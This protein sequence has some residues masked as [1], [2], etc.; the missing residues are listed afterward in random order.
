MPTAHRCWSRQAEADRSMVSST[1]EHCNS[2]I[3]LQHPAQLA[4]MLAPSK[5]LHMLQVIVSSRC[6][7]VGNWPG[8]GH[9]AAEPRQCCCG[10]GSRLPGRHNPGDT[11]TA[12]SISLAPLTWG[13]M[14]YTYHLRTSVVLS[15]CLQC[16]TCQQSKSPGLR[17]HATGY[18]H[19]QQQQESVV[20]QQRGCIALYNLWK[21]I[22]FSDCLCLVRS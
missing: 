22:D 19:A 2:G 11:P 3:S 15:I 6:G 18:E 21:Q 14:F 4:V 9:G 8:R 1:H 13:T 17:E 5:L 7:A 16:N 10:G 12:H 20:V